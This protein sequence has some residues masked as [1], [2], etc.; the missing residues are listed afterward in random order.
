PASS[1]RSRIPDQHGLS[2]SVAPRHEATAL[3]TG[4][5]PQAT[6]SPF[7]RP[8]ARMQG[9]GRPIR[10]RPRTRNSSTF[11]CPRVWQQCPGSRPLPVLQMRRIAALPIKWIAF[12]A[13][14][15][16][17]RC[18]GRYALALRRLVTH[19]VYISPVVGTTT[20]TLEITHTLIVEIDL[21]M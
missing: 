5:P 13:A 18:C 19:N 3:P 11:P 6:S 21:Q 10:R 12:P 9:G 8:E 1:P 14:P 15:G 7:S 2:R 20:T 16:S 17:V 4:T